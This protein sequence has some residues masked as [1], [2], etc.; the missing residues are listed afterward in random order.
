MAKNVSLMGN[1]PILH[2]LD[3][4]KHELKELKMNLANSWQT[5]TFDG[6]NDLVVG[7]GG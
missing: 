5:K 3:R 6:K 4:M 1:N 7:I 2:T